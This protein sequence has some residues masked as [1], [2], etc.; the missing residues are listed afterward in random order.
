MFEFF[1][2]CSKKLEILRNSNFLNYIRK[3]SKAPPRKIKC[4]S[5]QK[6]KIIQKDYK[7]FKQFKMRLL[8]ILMIRLRTIEQ[9]LKVFI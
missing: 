9:K 4:I 5:V 2:K 3:N 7:Y 1:Q 6:K 8:F